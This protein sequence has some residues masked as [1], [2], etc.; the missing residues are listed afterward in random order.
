MP[1]RQMQRAPKRARGWRV[2]HARFLLWARHEAF[3]HRALNDCYQLGH[4]HRLLD[5]NTA[6]RRSIGRLMTAIG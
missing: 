4:T 5:V 1:L 3:C 6:A 2:Y